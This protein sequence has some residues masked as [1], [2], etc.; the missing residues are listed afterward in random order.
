MNLM[1]IKWEGLFD[2][3][4]DTNMPS[5]GKSFSFMSLDIKVKNNNYIINVDIPGCKKRNID[6][7]LDNGY[8]TISAERSSEKNDSTENYIHR[9][10][11]YG[12]TSRSIYVGDDIKTEDIKAKF[13]DGLLRINIPKKDQKEVES[14]KNIEIE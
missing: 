9:E 6:L 8:L 7:K 12:K 13:E 2:D 3:F 14:K 5:K 1:P 11:Y 10:R 4:F